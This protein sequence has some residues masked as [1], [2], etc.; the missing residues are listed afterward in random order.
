MMAL[1][2]KEASGTFVMKPV[3]DGVRLDEDP[4]KSCDWTYHKHCGGDIILIVVVAP[5]GH[6]FT[7][8]SRYVLA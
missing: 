5:I 3:E 2:H 4:I 7:F 6:L 8:H 1:E